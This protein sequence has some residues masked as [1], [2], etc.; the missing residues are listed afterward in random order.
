MKEQTYW[1]SSHGSGVYYGGDAQLD[2]MTE[3]ADRH[4]DEWT[5]STVQPKL[6]R[7]NGAL[8]TAFRNP[9]SEDIGNVP[10]RIYINGWSRKHQTGP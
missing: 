5:L 4:G 7:S 3:S 1:I 10:R 8:R 6:Y 9:E 2:W